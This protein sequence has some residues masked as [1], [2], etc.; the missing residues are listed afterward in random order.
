MNISKDKVVY[1][2]FTLRDDEGRVLDS[3]VGD[4]ALPYLH[5]HGNLIPGLEKA[6]EG[7]AS[8]ERF[9]VSIPPVEPTANVTPP[10]WSRCRARV[11][12][13]RWWSRSASMCRPWGR[14]GGWSSPSPGLTRRW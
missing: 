8:G 4:E 14:R 1:I 9:S 12:A 11:S 7:R 2:H 5:G 6:L 10:A 3:N 13:P